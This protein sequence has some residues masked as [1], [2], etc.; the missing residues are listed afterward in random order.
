MSRTQKLR[1]TITYDEPDEDQQGV[2]S[3]LPLRLYPKPENIP[4]AWQK[5]RATLFDGFFRRL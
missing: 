5:G 3:E 2:S 4:G 1:L